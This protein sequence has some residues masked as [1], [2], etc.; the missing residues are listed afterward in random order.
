MFRL[1]KSRTSLQC[2]ESIQRYGSDLVQLLEDLEG[3]KFIQQNL[4]S[5]LR[6]EEGRQLLAEVKYADFLS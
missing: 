6:Q 2:F 5:L 3:G 4:E 1:E